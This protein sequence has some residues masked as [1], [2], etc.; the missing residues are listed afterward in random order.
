MDYD[1][2]G[3]HSLDVLKDL[4]N[5]S[6]LKSQLNV[7]NDRKNELKLMNNFFFHLTNV[8]Y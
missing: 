3:G 7:K 2:N 1:F 5:D 8:L 6:I 4:R